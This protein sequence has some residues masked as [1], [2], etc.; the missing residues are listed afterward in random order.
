MVNGKI[1]I[2]EY[3][4]GFLKVDGTSGLGL[5]NVL[6]DAIK[7]FGLDIDYIRDK[8]MIMVLI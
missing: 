3:F 1:K 2:E 5:C 8:I 7:S 6:V 4:I